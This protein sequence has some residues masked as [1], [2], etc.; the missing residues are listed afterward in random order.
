M[1][2]DNIAGK[3]F[4]RLLVISRAENKT[5]H[6][7]WNCVCDCS[8]EK[9]IRSSHLKSGRIVSCGCHR[10]DQGKLRATH[11][12]ANKTRTYRIWRNMKVRCS[13]KTTPDYFRYGGRGITVCQRWLDSFENFLEDMGVCP[14]QLSID[15]IDVNGNYEPG[16]CRWA[17][18]K[19]QANNRRFHGSRYRKNGILL[20][21]IAEERGVSF[22]DYP[23]RQ[24]A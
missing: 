8:A 5:N 22:N 10:S 1:S 3:R 2:I 20:S 17:T 12:M 4:G 6:T 23:E 21:A 7:M 15:R 19:E 13:L 16:N 24:A 9:T 14:D 18:A 11:G